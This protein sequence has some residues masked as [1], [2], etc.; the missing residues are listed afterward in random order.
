MAE[1]LRGAWTAQPRAADRGRAWPSA[2]SGCGLFRRIVLPPLMLAAGP[3]VGNQIDPDHQGQR[4]P[5][6]H[7]AARAHARGQLD[8][9]APLHPVRRLHRRGAA[10]LGP[11]PGGRGRRVGRRPRWRRRA[12]ERRRLPR[13]RRAGPPRR[14][15]WPRPPVL[16][17]AGLVKSF[18]SAARCSTTSIF[19]WSA[20]RPSAC[21]GLRARASRRCCAASTGSSGPT[22]AASCSKASTIGV[23]HRRRGHGRRRARR[24]CARASAWCSSTSRCGRT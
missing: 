14:R 7:R 13:E 8:P 1:I 20:A 17:V 3:V 11:V 16:S 21:S 18:G 10:V 4:L 12:D 5:H 2:I 22:P 19:R 24:A 15:R 23:T 9:V 6:H